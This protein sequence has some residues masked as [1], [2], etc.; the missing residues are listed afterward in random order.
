MKKLIFI[1][2]IFCFSVSAQK[3]E[4]IGS[5][6]EFSSASSFYVTA[7]GY[8]YVCDAGKDELI[9]L[10]TL[11]NEY[12][13]FGGYGWSD[14]SFDDPADVFAD[15]LTIYVADKNNH[16]IKRLDK[17][18]NFLSSFN[19]KESNFSEE[20]F[21]YPL[22]VATSNQGDLY[23]IDSE[24]KR[25]I[26]FDI[27]GSFIQNFGGIDAGAYQLSNPLQLAIS[28]ANNIYVLDNK[29]IIVFDNFGNGVAKLE[30]GNK[31][32][33]IRILFDVLVVTD[34]SDKIYFS[35]LRSIDGKIHSLAINYNFDKEKIVSA[36]MLNGK[37][38]LLTDK[39][40]LVFANNN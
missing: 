30:F 21:G 2:F 4:N 14:D 20:Q 12:K 36:L 22:S 37:L 8:L 10:D 28:S 9:M 25:V 38:Y 18:L 26:K 11:G 27:Y 31:L 29:N 15:P 19:K 33:S 6:G 35:N 7:N 16:A 23:L 24:N 13:T 34:N 1:F 3:F 17:N 32:K 39:E 40:I 5:I